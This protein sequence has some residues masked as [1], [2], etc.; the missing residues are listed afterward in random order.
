ML[1]RPIP[2]IGWV[3]EVLAVVFGLGVTC[4]EFQHRRMSPELV[5][6]SG[7]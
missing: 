5:E 2:G 4:M 1:L 3:I 7:E 6:G